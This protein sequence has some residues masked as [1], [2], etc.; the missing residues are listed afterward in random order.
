MA[1]HNTGDPK[2]KADLLTNYFQDGQANNS[3]TASDM[4]DSIESTSNWIRNSGGWEFLFDVDYPNNATPLTAPN[5]VPTK[6]TITSNPGEELRYPPGFPGAWDDDNNKLKPALLNGFGIIR[7]SMVGQY[8]GGTAPHFE[9]QL[10]V[11]S[12]PIAPAGTGTA[13]N[14]IFTETHVFAKSQN[15]SQHFNSVMPLFVGSDFSTNGGHFIIT[16]TAADVRLFQIT[17]TAARI[18]APD[19]SAFIG[20]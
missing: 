20:A 14:I 16:A 7:L 2:T 13:S 11:G 18:F 10:D 3:I 6:I 5:G 15:D 4:R 12:D 19:P 1:T 8:S 9:L 17:M